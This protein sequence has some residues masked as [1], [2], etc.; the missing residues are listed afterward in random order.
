MVKATSDEA[1]IAKSYASF[2][3]AGDK[4]ICMDN[5]NFVLESSCLCAIST[6][7]SWD[8]EFSQQTVWRE[9]VPHHCL[10]SPEIIFLFVGI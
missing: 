5:V 2:L 3:M 8:Q 9:S 4:I 7:D 10:Y 1:E 6:N